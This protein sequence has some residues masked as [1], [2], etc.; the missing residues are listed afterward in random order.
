MSDRVD[1][2]MRGDEAIA[3]VAEHLPKWANGDVP[4]ETHSL[5]TAH[6]IVCIALRQML[7]LEIQ[8]QWRMARAGIHVEAEDTV[9]AI[10]P[11]EYA[12]L[13]QRGAK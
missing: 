8:L 7:A 3:Y 4:T 9:R 11:D 13:T 12:A 6:G 10:H 1:I 2:Q 5:M